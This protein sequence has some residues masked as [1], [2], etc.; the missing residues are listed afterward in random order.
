M[1]DESLLVKHAQN[2][3]SSSFERLY[4]KHVKIVYGFVYQKTGNREDCEDL[5]QEIWMNVIKN[6]RDFE[7][8]SSFKNWIFGITKHKLMDYY[9][10]KYQIGFVPLVE[11]IF[12][13]EDETDDSGM[14]KNKIKNLLANLP[15]NYRMVL[16]L[17]FLKGYKTAEIAKELKM[18]VNNVKVI[19]FRAIQKLKS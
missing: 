10:E 4:Q 8:K 17:R 19:Q 15:E 11:E 12:L 6:L 16:T 18:T 3:D 13:E 5:T 1:D 14:K 2:G 9:K 7:G